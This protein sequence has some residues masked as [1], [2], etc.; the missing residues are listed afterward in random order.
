MDSLCKYYSFVVWHR[1]GKG[2]ILKISKEGIVLLFNIGELVADKK[3]IEAQATGFIY[4]VYGYL[5]LQTY[6]DQ[7][8]ATAKHLDAGPP[9]AVALN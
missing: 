9:P 2:T 1:Q 4:V 3:S 6:Y 7:S 8:T 5:C